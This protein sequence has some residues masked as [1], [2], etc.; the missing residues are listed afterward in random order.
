MPISCREDRVLD[1]RI[2]DPA[3]GSGHFLVRACQYLAEEIATNPYTSDQDAD[4]LTEVDSILTFWKRRVAERCIFGV[5]KNPLAVELAKLALWLETVAKD[6]P[7]AF[8]DHHLRCGNSLVGAKLSRLDT[9]HGPGLFQGLF[10]NEFLQKKEELLEPLRKLRSIDSNDTVAVKAKERLLNQYV[11]RAAGFLALGHLWCSVFF[12]TQDRRQVADTEYAEL[13]KNLSHPKRLKQLLEPWKNLIEHTR[14]V[15]WP[16]HWE[17]EF[18]E[19]FTDL[20]TNKPAGFDAIIGNPPYDVL[21]SKEVAAD[22]LPLKKF[23]EAQDEYKPSFV[24]KNNLYKLFTAKGLDLLRDEGFFGFIVPMALLGDEY[25][26]GIRRALL[27]QGTFLAIHAFPQKDDVKNRVFPEAKLSTVVFVMKK[28]HSE[29]ERAQRF[30]ISRHPGRFIV[31]T[32]LTLHLSTI[33]IPRY[34]PSNVTLVSC[35]Q[36]DWDL[37][38]RLMSQPHFSRLG[39]WSTSFQG[40][41]NETTDGERGFLSPDART[42]QQ[43]LRGANVCLY[44]VREASQGEAIFV[45]GDDLLRKKAKG[46]K[47]W[48]SQERR[49][50]FQ[51]SAPQNNFRRIIAAPIPQG[52]YC[53]DTVSYIPESASKLAP[54]MLLALLNSKILEWYFRLGSSNSKLNEYQFNNLPCP[55][56]ASS[57][58]DSRVTEEVALALRHGDGAK[59]H[60]IVTDENLCMPPFAGTTTAVLDSLAVKISTIEA[61]RGSVSKRAR[62]SIDPEAQP[63]QVLIDTILFGMAGFSRAEVRGIEDRLQELV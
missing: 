32:S 17:L 63:Y 22:L 53:F 8:L 46:S 47:A 23:F 25:A 40:E 7:L 29:E 48:H 20:P 30:S 35:S 42:G 39:K 60:E 51:R 9:L 3:M 31:R 26:I 38:V 2:L 16:F 45:R 18:P 14:Q 6:Q 61:D 44:A 33:E 56:F 13:V 43:V 12:R 50:G 52:E 28:T 49:I 24:G 54:G 37:A 1:L 15:V 4:R 55:V 59:I 62:A 21:A 19:V 10:R 34:D 27:E 36:E 57:D 58:V 11:A 5:D 41:I